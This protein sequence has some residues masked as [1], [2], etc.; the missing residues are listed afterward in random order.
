M[1]R[2]LTAMAALLL[3]C[4]LCAEVRNKTDTFER[5]EVCES[6]IELLEGVTPRTDDSCHLVANYLIEAKDYGATKFFRDFEK[7]TPNENGLLF[8]MRAQSAIVFGDAA[9]AYFWADIADRQVFS[10][11]LSAADEERAS[12]YSSLLSGVKVQAL[13]SVCTKDDCSVLDRYIEPSEVL[14]NGFVYLDDIRNDFVLYC[15]LRTDGYLLPIRDVLLSPAFSS[16][17]KTGDGNTS[18][19]K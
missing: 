6:Y 9:R 13:K 8:M 3:P 4:T 19:L 16:C 17:L 12:L 7:R 18:R 5:S 10:D 15:L 2:Y 14:G 11:M 1:T